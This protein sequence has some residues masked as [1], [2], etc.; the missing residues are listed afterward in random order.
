MHELAL[1]FTVLFL[2]DTDSSLH[3][4]EVRPRFGV[5]DE[6]FAVGGPL[7]PHYEVSQAVALL[8]IQ[9]LLIVIVE[10]HGFDERVGLLGWI[11]LLQ[12]QSDWSLF[13]FF[14]V[15]DS[16]LKQAD[17]IKIGSISEER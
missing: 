16:L 10:L 14:S 13:V 11:V 4:E 3:V 12:H 6:I 2:V 1:C 7:A 9:I 17:E 5:Q 15:L 8:D